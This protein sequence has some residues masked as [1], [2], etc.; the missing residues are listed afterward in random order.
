MTRIDSFNQTQNLLT[1]VLRNQQPLIDR[2]RQIATGRRSD[3]FSGYSGEAATL[4]GSKALAART[5]QFIQNNREIA[6]QLDVYGVT[7]QALGD[8]ASNLRQD[9]IQAVNNNTGS[10][11]MDKINSL[12]EQ[13]VTLLN[14]SIEGR[15]VFAGTRTDTAPVNISTPSELIALSSVGDAFDNNQTKVSAQV[16]VGSTLEYGLLASDAGTALFT[17]FQRIMQFNAG[18]L[19]SGAGSFGP[20][21]AFQNPLTDNQR[22]FLLSELDN[23]QAAI[24]AV[25]AQAT[26]NG[27][28]QN[29]MDRIAERQE[30]DLVFLRTFISEI[31]DVDAAEAISRL[32][33]DQA[34]FEASLRMLSDLGRLSLLDF[35]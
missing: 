18:T 29:T 20:A 15:F 16:D 1:E 14:T 10:G 3:A 6:R 22:A 9:V 25:N 35:I 23:L 8:V 4:T 24:D 31:E 26:Q 21:G 34:A 7:L 28:R 30:A 19:P 12:F 2:Q 27:I 11:L 32:N 5:E 33:Q 17:A 13:A